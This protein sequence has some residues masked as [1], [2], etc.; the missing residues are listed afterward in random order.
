MPL[1]SLLS[2]VSSASAEPPSTLIEA[3]YRQIRRDIVLGVHPPG[4][5]LRIEQ[6]KTRYAASSGTLREAL[7]L[8]VSDDLVVAQGQRGFSVAPMSLEDLTD[9]S[10]VR[11]LVEAEAAR[12]SLLR[13]DDDWEARL[14]SAFHKL[15]R[16]EERLAARTADVYEEWE[17]R[18]FE[19]HE[20]LVSACGSPRLLSLRAML[21][22]QAERYRRVSALS[23]PRPGSVHA[24]HE[25]IFTLALARK[26][27]A[28][29]EVIGQHVRRS[30]DVIRNSGLLSARAQDGGEAA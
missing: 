28:L 16:T 12:Q 10:Y 19:F 13:G 3:A 1:E 4:E 6:L 23:G 17:L 27:D 11:S 30:L 9:L 25:Q 7:A 24:E 29:A 21:H 22:L 14:V 20:A 2:A 18:N 5:R 26:G 8:L 15:T